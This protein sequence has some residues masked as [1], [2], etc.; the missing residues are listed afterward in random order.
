[1]LE[2]PNVDSHVE[3]EK[4]RKEQPSAKPDEAACRKEQSQTKY[5]E[6]G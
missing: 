1:M 2:K 4:E 3:N 5:Q 6:D